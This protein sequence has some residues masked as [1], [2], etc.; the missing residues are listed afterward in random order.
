MSKLK[1]WWNHFSIGR[2]Q[3]RRRFPA[4]VLQ[5]I[6]QAVR[7]C[8]TLHSGEIRF[9]VEAAL[10]LDAIFAGLG[11][12]QRAI[13][14]FAQLRVWDTEHN[15]GVLIYVLFA[16]RAVEIVADRGVSGEHVA[17]REWDD[18]CRQMEVAFKAGQFEQGAVAGVHGIADVL[19][20]H[21][22]G[23]RSGSNEQPDAPILL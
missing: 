9:V 13:E 15:N 12:R 22:P 1:R 20:R 6:E 11:P 14:L 2:W 7:D 8:E 21:A 4:P 23:V 16:D 17:A 5:A 18:V 3:L 19:A 10:P